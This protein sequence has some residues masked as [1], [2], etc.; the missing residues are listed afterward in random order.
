MMVKVLFLFPRTADLAELEDFL[1]TVFVPGLSEAPEVRSVRASHG[2]VMSP[3]GP[4]PYSRIVEA[5]FGS[6]GDVIA[7]VEAP[8]AQPVRQR[9]RDFG[10]LVLMY[11]MGAS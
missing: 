3:G 11:D 9:I 2:D 4:P 7:N 5:E 8:D 1:Q 10:A 6:L